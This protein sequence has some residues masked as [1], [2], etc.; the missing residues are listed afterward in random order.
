MPAYL[1]TQRVFAG[2][3]FMGAAA[4]KA[5]YLGEVR[6]WPGEVLVAEAATFAFAG[7]AIR[8]ARPIV[9][10]QAAAFA[11]TGLDAQLEFGL[12]LFA[13]PGSVVLIGRDAGLLRN[14]FVGT[15]AAG[16]ALAG[17]D[18][19]F[20]RTKRVAAETAT[21]TLAGNDVGLFTDPLLL[22]SGDQQSGTDALA[23]SGDQEPGVI[24]VSE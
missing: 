21:F 4:V 8:F 13:D 23:L 16:F 14:L 11:L 18:A 10:P 9:K 7:Q 3:L 5:L 17:A 15:D 12:R 20:I 1:G 19:T 6:L 24:I 2:Q 22:L